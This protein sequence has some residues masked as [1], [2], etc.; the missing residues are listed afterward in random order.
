MTVKE[1]E[2]FRWVM[3]MFLHGSFF[4]IVITVLLQLILGSLIEKIITLYRASIIYFLSGLGAVLFGALLSNEKS[5]GASG[6]IFGL[7]SAFLGWLIL[8]WELLDYDN[9]PRGC[10]LCFSIMILFIIFLIG[11][12]EQNTDSYG[13]IG[14]ML[15]GIIAGIG[16]SRPLARLD[17]SVQQS[18]SYEEKLQFI[19]LVFLGILFAV[20]FIIFFVVRKPE[21]QPCVCHGEV[22]AITLFHHQAILMKCFEFA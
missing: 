21:M 22:F 16:F 8:N 18:Y 5:V 11:L 12:S 19:A 7:C 14:G 6:A 15:T 20:G 13:H 2:W 1:R 4:Q 10:L 3:P 17:A 9:S